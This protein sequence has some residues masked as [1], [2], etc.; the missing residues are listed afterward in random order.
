MTTTPLQPTAR[1]SPAP[2]EERAAIDRQVLYD[3]LLDGMFCHLRWPGRRGP[4]P[5]QAAV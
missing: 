2:L 5:R 3:V 1:T 4:V